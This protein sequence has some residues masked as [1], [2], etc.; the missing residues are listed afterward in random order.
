MLWA[1]PLGMAAL[2]AVN[3][4]QKQ[5][6]QEASNKAQAELT[7]YSPWTGMQGKLDFSAP[8]M[9]GGAMQGGV[10]GLGMAQGIQSMQSPEPT[11]GEIY[12][13]TFGQQMPEP[14]QQPASYNFKPNLYNG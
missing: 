4:K 9:L 2:G 11:S 14:T 6:Q 13:K 12:Q 3:A 1:I 7:R 8:S 10:A 5:E